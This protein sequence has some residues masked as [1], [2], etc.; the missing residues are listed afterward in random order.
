[1]C[2][3]ISYMISNLFYQN[4]DSIPGRYFIKKPSISSSC[5]FSC[6]AADP[7]LSPCLRRM[8]AAKV[9]IRLR[10]HPPLI[11]CAWFAT[12]VTLTGWL[13]LSSFLSEVLQGLRFRIPQ[14]D[15]WQAPQ[16]GTI[17]LKSRPETPLPGQITLLISPLAEP[18][19][20]WYLTVKIAFLHRGVVCKHIEFLMVIDTVKTL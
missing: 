6:P 1:M 13:W 19:I 17:C 7:L 20:E 16:A 9:F 12:G 4:C 5:R 8:A 14:Y 15:M 18:E 10:T 2:Q 3:S 11:S